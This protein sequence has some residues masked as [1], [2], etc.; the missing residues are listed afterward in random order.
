M[1]DD[2]T[3]FLPGTATVPFRPRSDYLGFKAFGSGEGA[4]LVNPGTA[5]QLRSA[6]EY[7]ARENRVAG[8]LLYGSSWADHQG[9]YL[10]V[11]GYLEAGAGGQRRTRHSRDSHDDFSLSAEDLRLL[12]QDAVRMYSASYEVGWWRTLAE[13]GEFGPTD[14]LTQRELVG[15]DC[16]GLLVYGSDPH[17]GTA[18]LGPDGDAPDTAGTLVAVPDAGPPP[19]ADPEPDAGPEADPGPQRVD[20]GAGESL[21]LDAQLPAESEP[22]LVDIGAGE[23][24]L[25][26]EENEPELE[27][28]DIGAGMSLLLDEDPESEPADL[29]PGETLAQ[30]PVLSSNAMPGTALATRRPA[31]LSPV[32][33]PSAL[34]AL[35]PQRLPAREWGD[36]TAGASHIGAEMPTDVKIVVGG[37]ILSVVIAAII[38]GVLMSNAMVAVIVG[39]VAVLAVLGFVWF[40]HL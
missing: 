33:P 29:A 26:D 7:A 9:G 34:A 23:S 1:T 4:V 32:P 17:W 31:A 30:E 12:R 6:A 35:S 10:V 16:V 13:L 37:L 24:L 18:Y 38:I 20:I 19:A 22:E 40:S 2:G 5:R 28:V 3:S 11:D 27:R 21:A 36:R 15:P 8:G 25:L 14:F 39:A